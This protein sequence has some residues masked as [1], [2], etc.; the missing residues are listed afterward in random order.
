MR[1][2]WHFMLSSSLSEIKIN[3]VMLRNQISKV[4]VCLLVFWPS[5]WGLRVVD[6][7]LPSVQV[8]CNSPFF[9]H[10]RSSQNVLI[11][12][13]KIV[14]SILKAAK[15]ICLHQTCFHISELQSRLVF[16]Q[17]NGLVSQSF[18]RASFAVFRKHSIVFVWK[19]NVL[20]QERCQR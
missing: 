5:I 19:Y 17:Q 9:R 16:V 18:S 15:L 8:G 13:T 2:A 3:E 6:W 1:F 20:S 4:T 14:R 12:F 7:N 11:C 10:K